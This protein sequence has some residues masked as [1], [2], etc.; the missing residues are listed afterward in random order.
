MR[1]AFFDA[2]KA[3][4][5]TAQEG[6]ADTLVVLPSGLPSNNVIS[7]SSVKDDINNDDDTSS[8]LVVVARLGKDI[9]SPIHAYSI[10]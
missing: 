7:N 2:M 1:D 9:N 6:D 8:K 10:P 4:I 5:M 3:A